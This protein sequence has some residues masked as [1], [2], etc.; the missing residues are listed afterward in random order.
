MQ[1]DSVSFLTISGRGSYNDVINID[2]CKTCPVS[3]N[4]NTVS[5]KYGAE[6]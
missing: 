1:K 2:L 5:N 4:I 6:L 3:V